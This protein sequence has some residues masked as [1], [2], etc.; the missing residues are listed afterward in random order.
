MLTPRMRDVPLG[1]N[2][3]ST[4]HHRS[5]RLTFDRRATSKLMDE[6]FKLTGDCQLVHVNIGRCNN[7]KSNKRVPLS[8]NGTCESTLETTSCVL[9]ERK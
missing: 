1:A 6:N 4:I 7:G 2:A 5:N 9:N 3:S 8:V